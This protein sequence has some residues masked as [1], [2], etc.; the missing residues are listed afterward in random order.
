MG[1]DCP[2]S[3]Q[4]SQVGGEFAVSAE[5][6]RRQLAALKTLDAALCG[7]SRVACGGFSGLSIRLYHPDSCP[8]DTLSFVDERGDFNT[9]SGP[10]QV[11][12]VAGPPE[13]PCLHGGWQL[14]ALKIRTEKFQCCFDLGWYCA[15][16]VTP[17]GANPGLTARHQCLKP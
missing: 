7:A 3:I 6:Q 10:M 13:P 16:A 9:R 12:A 11:R 14:H 4:L 1:R 2:S 15:L 5:E 17:A 8:F